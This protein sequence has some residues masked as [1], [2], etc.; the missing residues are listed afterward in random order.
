[1]AMK[2]WPKEFAIAINTEVDICDDITISK[3]FETPTASLH[4]SILISSNVYGFVLEA[5]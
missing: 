4:P 1:M 5:A 3:S 2:R